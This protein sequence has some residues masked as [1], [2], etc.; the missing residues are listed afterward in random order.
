MYF[1]IILVI[2]N[3]L[4]WDI[5]TCLEAWMDLRL[6]STEATYLGVLLILFF[7]FKIY[8]NWIRKNLFFRNQKVVFLIIAIRNI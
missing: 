6:W 7:T 4:Y 3:L 8:N 2:G 5:E 1:F